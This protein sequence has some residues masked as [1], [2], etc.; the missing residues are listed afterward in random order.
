MSITG[1]PKI[2]IRHSPPGKLDH[3][4]M[5]TECQVIRGNRTIPEIYV[6][7]S[8]YEDDPLWEPSSDSIT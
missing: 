7:V 3:A 5:G 4:P 2:I 6:Q 8:Q 1:L